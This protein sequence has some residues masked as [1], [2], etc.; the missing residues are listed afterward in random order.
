[1]ARTRVFISSTYYDLKHIRA[2]LD[3]FVDSMGFDSILSE[4]G[5]IAYSPDIPLDESCYKE[6]GTADIFVAVIGGRYGSAASRENHT[7]NRSDF[8]H[9]YDSITKLEITE[10]LRRDIPVYIAI[11]SSVYAEYQ[12][13]TRNKDVIGVKYAHVDSVNIFSLIEDILVR[14]KNN[15]IKTFER[16]SEIETW[17][18]EQWSGLFRELLSRL[19]Q[20]KQLSALHSE[21]EGMRDA[22]ETLK[23]YLESL[24]NTVAPDKSMGII[25]DETESSERRQRERSILRNPLA[26][27]LV[28]DVGIPLSSVTDAITAA[29]DRSDFSKRIK[30]A[31]SE[32]EWADESQ[33]KRFEHNIDENPAADEDIDNIRHVLGLDGWLVVDASTDGIDD[34]PSQ[35]PAR[36]ARRK[37]N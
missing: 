24:L 14:P 8:Y 20:Q 10:A 28:D 25:A 35:P 22:N 34:G 26:R 13:Y 6:V 9:R 36:Q 11:E 27:Y 19:S 33:R 18:R 29:K 3:V 16:F 32:L 17:L 21:I 31:A 12:T 7:V 23:S 1:M 30:K 37:A 2:S 5:D 4:K 15:P